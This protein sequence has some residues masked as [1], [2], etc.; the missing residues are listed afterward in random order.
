MKYGTTSSLHP[1]QNV[2]T[3]GPIP[4]EP[5]DMWFSISRESWHYCA[6]STIR[7]QPIL[8]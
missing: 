6:M 8:L 3:W 2:L 5:S 1:R 4:R 7:C